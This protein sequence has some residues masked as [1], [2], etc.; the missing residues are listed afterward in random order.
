MPPLWRHG[1]AD[2]GRL[3]RRWLVFRDE[4]MRKPDGRDVLFK[5]RPPL[6]EGWVSKQVRDVNGGHTRFVVA[7]ARWRALLVGLDAE[8]RRKALSCSLTAVTC[9]IAVLRR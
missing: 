7:G 4:V 9:Q 5:G 1:Q 6:T 8:E 2:P 3:P